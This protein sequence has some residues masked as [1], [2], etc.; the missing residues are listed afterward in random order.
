MH[1]GQSAYGG[2][3]IAQIKDELTGKWWKFNDSNVTE[4]KFNEV[5]ESDSL[6][7]SFSH[8][9]PKKGQNSVNQISNDC[10]AS[11]NAYMLIYTRKNREILNDVEIPNAV[12]DH[13]FSQNSSLML[14]VC[15]LLFL[16][17]F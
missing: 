11:S 10:L 13:V 8:Q 12:N 16:I 5:G 17:F 1:L 7:D 9:T 15:F 14:L 4:I 6:Y 2:H 3:Y